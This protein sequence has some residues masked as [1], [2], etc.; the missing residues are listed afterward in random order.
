M[1][2]NSYQLECSTV[3]FDF[4]FLHVFPQTSIYIAVNTSKQM[5]KIEQTICSLCN[6]HGLHMFSMPSIYMRPTVKLHAT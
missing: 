4:V 2:F 1:N 3:L 5:H 6:A